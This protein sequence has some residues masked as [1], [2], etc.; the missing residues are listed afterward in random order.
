M[1]SFNFKFTKR[2]IDVVPHPERG[3]KLYRD[4]TLRGFGLRVGAR[5]K[6]FYVEGQVQGRTRRAAAQAE[7]LR[8]RGTA[9]PTPRGFRL[10]S[11]AKVLMRCC[12]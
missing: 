6:A 2:T 7:K 5:S 3:Q 12:A 10:H 9:P 11:D 1:P 4:E 8:Y